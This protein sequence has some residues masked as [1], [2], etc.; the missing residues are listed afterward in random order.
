EREKKSES[1]SGRDHYETFAEDH[2]LHRFA[3]RAERHPDA[4]L[5]RP[6]RDGIRFHAIYADDRKAKGESAENG[7]QGGSRADR[8]ELRVAVKMLGERSHLEQRQ[9]GIDILDG[10]AQQIG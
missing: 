3:L 10:P 7:E 4:D 6:A 5:A 2:P 1:N 9:R 8:P